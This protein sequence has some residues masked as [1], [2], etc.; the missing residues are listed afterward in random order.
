MP[1]LLKLI[2]PANLLFIALTQIL[3]KYA[4]LHNF[5]ASIMLNGFGFSLLVLANL[6]LA[7]AGY[8]INDIYDQ[9]A[10]RI[11]KPEKLIVG[12][13]I[14]ENTAFNW[15]FALNII[16]VGLGFYLA[17]M[18]GYPVF[19]GIFVFSSAVLYL[20]AAY[21]KQ[22]PLLGNILVSCFVGGVVILV[23]L[24]ELL[25]AINTQNKQVQS[26]LFSI[27]LD[28]AVFAFL[29]NLLREM[30]KD[31]QDVQGDHNT[32]RK[33]LAVILGNDR[34][35]KLIFFVAL[36]PLLL[37]LHYMYTYLFHNLVAVLYV[38]LLLIAPLLYVMVRIWAASGKKD[39]KHLSLILKI[40]L[41][42]GL[43]SIAF[44]PFILN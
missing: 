4:L 28:Y 35:N 26:L 30:V 12:K 13:Y 24:F 18:V 15:F 23:G 22:V 3:V 17:N 38:L 16:G 21:L 20:Y 33:T 8:I 9:E 10:D 14:S 31:Q 37:I 2:R 42:F 29:I 5:G 7:A 44:L 39:Y 11:N 34:N 40:I 32:G 19:S 43:I 6:C 25:P 36:I 1:A 27:L 41:F